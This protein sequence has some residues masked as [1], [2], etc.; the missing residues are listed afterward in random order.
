MKSIKKVINLLKYNLGAFIK[1]EF[2]YKILSSTIFFPLLVGFFNLSLKL[3]HYSYITYENIFAYLSN[4]V[5]LLFLFLLLIL[6]TIFTLIDISA[7]IYIIDAS[8][9]K[10]KTSFKSVLPFAVKNAFKVIHPKNILMTLFVL[11][12]IP[13]FSVGLTSVFIGNIKIPEFIMSYLWEHVLFLL[14]FVAVVLFIGY[15]VLKWIYSF[16]YFTLE[17]CSF[18]SAC[19]KSSSLHRNHLLKDFIVLTLLQLACLIIFILLVA[20]VIFIIFIITKYLSVK[21][22]L[23]SIILGLIVLII[24]VLFI[25]FFLLSTP[26]SFV[27]ISVMYY[28]HKEKKQEE[29]KSIPKEVLYKKTSLKLK[30]AVVILSFICIG[31]LSVYIHLILVNQINFNIEYVRNIE[32]TAHRGSSM[33]YPE[34]TMQAFTMAKNAN[35]DYIELDVQ[36]TKDSI[37]IIMHDA[38]LSRTTGLK[39]H[40]WEVTYDEIKDLDNGSWFNPKFKHQKI[41]TLEEVLIFAKQNHIKLNIELKSTG[42]EKDFEKVIIDKILEYDFENDSIITSGDYSIL[43]NVKKYNPDIKT[44]YIMSIAYGNIF[45]FKDADGYSIEATFITKDLVSKCHNRGKFILA[46]TVN[47]KENINKMIDLNV[48]NI[49]TDDIDLV[50]TTIYE[51]K[52]S[53]VVLEYIK[54]LNQ[55]IH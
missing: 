5:T 41:P 12:M 24:N 44:A 16:H 23:Y 22:I 32:V 36:M 20:F 33:H 38:S 50:K 51:S 46:W 15:F 26:I 53:N 40:V 34:N 39:K 9:E 11:M 45:D 19:K 35:A 10:K 37:P 17:N 55:Y 25:G 27:C 49:I 4:P 2:I 14:L 42:H 3:T 7:I 6:I 30:V 48:D 1:F 54:F 31:L 8:Y 28:H 52:T 13:F 47:N 18:P 43:E 21:S 29:I